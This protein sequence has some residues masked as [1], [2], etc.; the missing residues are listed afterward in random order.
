MRDKILDNHNHNHNEVMKK[1]RRQM[2][3]MGIVT[4]NLKRTVVCQNKC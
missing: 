1:K 3:I 2:S 4:K